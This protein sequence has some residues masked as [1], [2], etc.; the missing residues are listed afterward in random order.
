MFSTTRR[1]TVSVENLTLDRCSFRFGGEC[2]D[3]GGWKTAYAPAIGEFTTLEFENKDWLSGLAGYVYFHNADHTQFVTLAFSCP[4]TTAACFTARCGSSLPDCQGLLSRVPDLGRPGTGLRREAGCAWETQELEDE[5]V[6]V[7]MIILPPDDG[8]LP[9]ELG[10]RLAKARWCRSTLTD[11]A[12]I[13]APHV[14][15]VERRV[16]LEIDNR[17]EENLVLDG[18]WFECGRWSGKSVR[19]LE[20]GVVTRLEFTSDEVF[21]GLSGVVWY[22]SESSLDT[23]FSATFTNPI[24]GDSTFNAWAGPPP[25]ELLQELYASPAVSGEG[26]Q[27]P[28]GQGCAWNVI[29]QGSTVHIRIVILEEIAAMDP[30]AYPP[31]SL[32]GAQAAPEVPKQP[33]A[34]VLSSSTA[35]ASVQSKEEMADVSAVAKLMDSTRPRDALDGLGSGL[36][37]AGAGFLAGTTMLVAAPMVAAREDG[38]KGFFTGLATGVCGAV[39][40]YVGGAVAATTQVVRGVYNTPEAISSAGKK[41]DVDTGAWI[42][43]SCNLRAEALKAGN[44][45]DQDGSD[46]EVGSPDGRPSRKVADT[47]LYDTIGAKPNA[48]AADLKKAYYKAALRLHPDKNTD[49]PEAGKKFQELS[50][51]YQV[52]SDP[53][54]R[55]R[56]DMVGAEAVNDAALPNI[57]PGLFFSMLF[58]AEQFEKYIGKLYLG[59]QFDH[60]AKDLQK[61]M[62]RA[63]STAGD[64]GMWGRDVLGNSLEREMRFSSDKKDQQMKRAQF[65]REVSC[66]TQ[67]VLRLDRLVMGRN[68]EGWVTSILQEASELSQVSFGGR[69]LRTIG[70]VYETV[71]EQHFASLR[72]NFTVESQFNS[73]RDS[74]HAAKVKVNAAGSMVRTAMAVKQMHDV[75]GSGMMEDEQ[76]KK[77]E[78]A[79]NAMQSFEGSLPV[80]L[81]TIWDVSQMDIE[82]TASKVCDKVLKDISVPWQIRHRRA[83]ALLRLGRIFRDAGQ[84]EMKDISEAQVA[85][86]HLEEALYSAIREKQR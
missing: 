30:L 70:S 69:L 38:V 11:S 1:L 84:V 21:R 73:W 54:L 24:A 9:E 76:A 81:Q 48:S 28:E 53:K 80:F 74:A 77:D 19:L 50:Q 26:V 16:V 46:D 78:A 51:A 15:L 64:D 72:G 7:R 75:A 45:D 62:S 60:I 25:A 42:E 12:P 31:A 40:C 85:K 32:G 35:L 17:T 34:P 39:G 13:D 43:D 66:A 33:Q 71:A 86:Q 63:Q 3:S 5:H 61:D 59:M 27:V 44:E 49:D 37:A 79:K 22:V 55:E 41:W 10:R 82:N 68:E 18:T 67:L 6:M 14:T 20:K 2:F 4:I 57:D 65:A 58:G 8:V 52:L 83:V 47:K 29:G 36:K 56:Y 23:Y